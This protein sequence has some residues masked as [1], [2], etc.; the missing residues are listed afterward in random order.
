M[1]LPWASDEDVA[2]PPRPG[3]EGG[4][5]GCLRARRAGR[6]R[7]SPRALLEVVEESAKGKTTAASTESSAMAPGGDNT[8][9]RLSAIRLITCSL[10]ESQG[11]K[12][13][14]VRASRCRRA[15]GPFLSF[16]EK[17]GPNSALS[18][19]A[20][21]RHAMQVRNDTPLLAEA[22]AAARPY[23]VPGPQGAETS[24]TMMMT[25]PLTIPSLPA[26]Q[27]AFPP[28]CCLGPPA[29]TLWS[30]QVMAPGSGS[31]G[32]PRLQCQGHSQD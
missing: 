24:K 29:T 27:G 18:A 19:R 23:R 1:E 2:F 25:E 30:A 5:D 12:R 13:D 11:D 31:G 21:L 7:A 14:N 4:H 10:S 22:G 28:P 15:R 20:A 3:R 26:Q 8:T 16:A 32:S 9:Y 6:I 17:L